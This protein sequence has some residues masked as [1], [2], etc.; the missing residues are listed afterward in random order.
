MNKNNWFVKVTAK[1]SGYNEL[2]KTTC[3][4]G[5][6][7]INSFMYLS[8]ACVVLAI[9]GCYFYGGYLFYTHGVYHE[10]HY[11]WNEWTIMVYEHFHLVTTF[12]RCCYEI[13]FMISPFIIIGSVVIG[14]LLLLYLLYIISTSKASQYLYKKINEKICKP[15]VY[16][17]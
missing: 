13:F 8:F 14:M 17:E 3:E 4:L 2:P 6:N 10:M 7:A 12:D 1:L 5:R 16:N 9:L 11:A 15:I